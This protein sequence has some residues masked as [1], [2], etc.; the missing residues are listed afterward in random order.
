MI[1][2]LVPEAIDRSEIVAGPV[3]SVRI[4]S[5]RLNAVEGE[6]KGVEVLVKRGRRPLFTETLSE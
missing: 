6:W 2:S 4:D 1:L 3:D 5:R